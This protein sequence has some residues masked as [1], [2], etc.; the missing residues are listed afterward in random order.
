[1]ALRM[2]GTE[3][4]VY[5]VGVRKVVAEPLRYAKADLRVI[6]Q[7]AVVTKA[8]EALPYRRRVSD[9][10]PSFKPGGSE[11]C[12]VE[13][14]SVS[15]KFIGSKLSWVRAVRFDPALPNVAKT[16]AAVIAEFLNEETGRAWPAQDLIAFES[17]R[18]GSPQ[19]SS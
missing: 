1:M 14:G 5:G 16:V 7:V 6:T 19:P 3:S 13:G 8:H 10:A 18:M 2:T 9:R 15:K 17:G 4:R 12:V 11:L